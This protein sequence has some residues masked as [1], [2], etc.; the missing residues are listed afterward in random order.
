MG[1]KELT[2]KNLGVISHLQLG[3]GA[4]LYNKQHISEADIQIA[5]ITDRDKLL[6]CHILR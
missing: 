3:K 4:L 1:P 5:F 6:K 2:L